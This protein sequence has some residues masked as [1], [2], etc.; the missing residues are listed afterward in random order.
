VHLVA[1]VLKSGFEVP[2][3]AV[4]RD[5][6]GA[7]VLTVGAD[8]N[9]AAKRVDVVSTAGNN[10]VI[11]SGLADGDQIIVSG[12]QMARPGMKVNPKPVGEGAEAPANAANAPA[13]AAPGS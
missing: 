13:T 7:F 5:N 10:W 11:G 6:Q 12:L 8:G 3:L 2:Q 1:G 4:Q 9:V